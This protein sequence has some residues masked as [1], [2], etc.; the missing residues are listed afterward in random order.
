MNLID[1]EIARHDWRNMPCGCGDSAEHLPGDLLRLAERGPAQ[2]PVETGLEEHVWSVRGLWDPAPA[3]TA[4]ALAA[5]ADETPPH[6][7]LL[8]LD[9]LHCMV[10]GDGTHPEAA[11][12]DLD[13]PA[14][15]GDLAAEGTWLLYREVMTYR[16]PGQAGSAFEILTAIGTD[17]DRLE[18]LREAA[19]GWL[20]VCCRTGLCDDWSDA[21]DDLG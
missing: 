16:N 7:R 20:P 18:R 11:R 19:A 5:L 6:A 13:L 4:V 8:Y 14:L 3:V 21:D 15:C 2:G 17:R 10:A 12:P 9:V 1:L